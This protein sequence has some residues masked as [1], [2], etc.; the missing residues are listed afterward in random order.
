MRY[1]VELH[2]EQAPYD[3]CPTYSV[4]IYRDTPGQRHNLVGHSEGCTSRIAALRGAMTS[5]RWR[6]CIGCLE[7]GT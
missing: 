5:V 3:W 4:F 2:K 7:V 1:R 6:R